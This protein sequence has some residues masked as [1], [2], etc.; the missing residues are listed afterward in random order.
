MTQDVKTIDIYDAQADAY[1]KLT[2]NPGE[3]DE[4]EAF[5]AA[6]RVGGRALDLGCGPGI[7]AAHMAARGLV[8]DAVDASREMV[9]LAAAQPGVAARM[10]RFEDISEIAVYD[11]IWANF[12]LL[13]APRREFSGHLVR[14]KRALKSGG[15]LHLGMK[16]GTGEGP[17]DIGRFYTYYGED[18]LEKYLNEAGFSISERHHG[19]GAGLSGEMADYITVLCHD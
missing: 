11:G 10:A 19:C 1:A 12:S 7:Y 15:V 8:V 5:V 13:H 4:L 16:L 6:V 17:D 3:M 18:E 14:L 2:Q 9:A